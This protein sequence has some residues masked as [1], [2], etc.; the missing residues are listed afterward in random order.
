MPDDLR[1]LAA[2]TQDVYERRA[3]RF[4]AERSKR[5]HE[6]AW[7]DRFL[8]LVAPGGLVLD[9]GCGAGDP[10]AAY[11]ASQGYR[12]VGVDASRAMLAIASQRYPD[13]DWRFGDMRTLDLPERFDGIIGWNSF[14]H[15]TAEEQRAVLPLLAA[16]LADDGA[17]MLT[18]GH[19][20]GEVEGRVGGDRVYHA[21]LDPEEYR[22]RLAE[23]GIP[24]VTFVAEDP[25][26]DHQ[27]VLLARKDPGG[28]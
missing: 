20:A 26:C 8:A 28:G 4:D 24:V 15:L 10:V 5:L 1:G 25:E 11:M 3:A 22:Q 18:V 7:L 27:T 16:H 13:G 17:L 21:S 6:R 14:F 23:L 12:V 2:T 19:E 9:L